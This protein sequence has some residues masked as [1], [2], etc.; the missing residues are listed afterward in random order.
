MV[1]ITVFL[2]Q[3]AEEVASIR[4]SLIVST[5]TVEAAM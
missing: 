1:L 5:V 4:K 3:F 2:L